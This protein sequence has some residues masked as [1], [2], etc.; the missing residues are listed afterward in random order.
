MV[1]LQRRLASSTRWHLAAPKDP[2]LDDTQRALFEAVG[3]FADERLAPLNKKDSLTEAESRAAFRAMGE[4]GILGVTVRAEDDGLGLGYTEHC[5]VMELVSR[6]HASLGLAY[7]AHSNLCVDQIRRHA[8]AAQRRRWLPRLL[9]GDAVGALAMTEPDAGTDVLAMRTT[10]VRAG[11][12]FVLNGT[13]TFITNGG[14]ADYYVVY[15]KTAPAAR[16]RG[17]S[18]FVVR[19]GTPGLSFSP[20]FDKFGMRG[21]HTCQVVLRNCRVPAA[22]LLGRENAGAQIL[23]GGLNTERLV[24]AAGPLGIM[25]ACLD[26]VLPYTKQRRQFGQPLAAF[27]LIQAKIADMYTALNASRALVYSAARAADAGVVSPTVC[28]ALTH[29]LSFTHLLTLALHLQNCAS[30]I[31]FSAENATKVALDTIQCLGG[32]GYMNEYGAGKLLADAKLYE[33]GAGTSEVRRTT[34]A[35]QTLKLVPACDA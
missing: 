17:I 22:A 6:A 29:S 20:H 25:A 24:L 16:H 5:H 2:L 34:I 35:K 18:A 12:A 31:L 8:T 33:I 4:L 13:K 26:L 7:G 30:A 27:Q 15:A 3:R 28:C 19:R 11:D 23:L 14:I 32:Y 9:A 1:L 21:S 10:A